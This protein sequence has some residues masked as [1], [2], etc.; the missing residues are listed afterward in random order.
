MVSPAAT[1]SP[2]C[3]AQRETVAS[4][5]DS[6]SG[7]T[8]IAIMREGAYVN[9]RRTDPTRRNSREATGQSDHSSNITFPDLSASTH[10]QCTWRPGAAR[11]PDRL[12]GS[13]CNQGDG[14]PC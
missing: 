9:E 10:P 11:A 4:T 5:T 8:L 14:C 1:A 3:L 13:R 2:G 12:A 7:G 6:P